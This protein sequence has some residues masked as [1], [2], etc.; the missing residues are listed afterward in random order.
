MARKNAGVAP[1]SLVKNKPKR[2]DI[3]SY[4]APFCRRKRLFRGEATLT[5]RGALPHGA[6]HER[7]P[8]HLHHLRDYELA[9]SWL[10]PSF[11]KTLRALDARPAGT[12]LSW[13]C[14][15]TIR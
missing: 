14:A 8:R 5:R 13:I 10:R 9:T 3:S 4:F 6:A 11:L 2:D 7:F 12:G 15:F 1:G